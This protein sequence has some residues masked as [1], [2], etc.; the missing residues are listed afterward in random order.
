MGFQIAVDHRLPLLNAIDQFEDAK[1][2]VR[3]SANQLKTDIGIFGSAAVENDGPTDYTD[4][5]FNQVR[6]SIGLQLDLPLDRLRERN[7][8]RAS[9]IG[10]ESELRN[11]SLTLDQLRSTI[12]EGIRELERLRKNYE[13]QTNAVLLAEKQ[14][15]G[16]QLSIESGN[17]IYRDLEEAQD[18]LIA[19]QN[20]QTAALVDYLAARLQLLLDLGILN[21]DTSQFWLTEASRIA[22]SPGTNSAN[23]STTI[24][25]DGEVITPDELFAQ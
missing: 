16:A 21:T 4:F 5:N 12:D 2:N 25:A 18:D 17:A 7:D 15:S 13:I 9:L 1:R 6:T 3:I 11:L 10:F 8:Y 14:V 23:D 19:A 20:A 22:L 24:S